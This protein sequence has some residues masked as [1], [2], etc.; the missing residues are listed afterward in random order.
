M[1][2]SSYV[3]V[4]RNAPGMSNIATS[5]SSY[6]SMRDVKNTA[7][8]HA[9]GD[10]ASYLLIYVRFLLP[11]S[12]SLPF[13]YPFIF[14]FKSI[15]EAT[16]FCLISLAISLGSCGMKVCILCSCKSSFLTEFP[17]L[18]PSSFSPLLRLYYVILI[19][20]MNFSLSFS[21]IALY[22]WFG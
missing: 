9:V 11:F 6:A 1:M 17:P 18:A 3:S 15:N 2:A 13:M 4:C 22:P 20:K 7:S 10:V 14:S 21:D 12:H 8:V 19:A 5:L 16:A